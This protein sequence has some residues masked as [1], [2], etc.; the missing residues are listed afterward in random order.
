MAGLVGAELGVQST[1]HVQRDPALNRA[2]E[3]L[4]TRA[5][6]LMSLAPEHGGAFEET[7]LRTL[8]PQARIVLV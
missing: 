7:R 4:R 2:R 5:D 6:F 3:E 1:G 8:F